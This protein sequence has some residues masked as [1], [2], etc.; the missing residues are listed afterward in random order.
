MFHA[1]AQQSVLLVIDVQPTFLKPIWEAERV[2]R[3]CGFLIEVA[4]LLGVPMLVT[5]QY[6]E[7]MGPTDEGLRRLLPEDTNVSPKM[8]FSCMGCESVSASLSQM[9]KRQ[10]ILCGI[11]THICVSQTA[12]HLVEQGLSVFVAAD[13]V[14][15]RTQDRHGLGIARMTAAGVI[16][17]HSESIVYEWMGSASH[18]K[19]REV[20]AIVKQY[21]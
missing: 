7:R 10:V 6:P 17:A 21:D 4:Q 9:G 5:E 2:V 11:E 12:H 19:F 18:P 14:S 8:S 15:A 1:D 16:A 20:L 13:A 3:R